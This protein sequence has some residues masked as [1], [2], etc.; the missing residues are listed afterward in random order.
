MFKNKKDIIE[1]LEAY[2]N[3]LDIPD[4]QFEETYSVQFNGYFKVFNNYLLVHTVIKDD[5]GRVW[6]IYWCDDYE[7]SREEITYRE[8]KFPYRVQKLY[9]S[10]KAEYYGVFRE[11]VESQKAINQALL[12][13]QLMANTQKIFLEKGA[14]ENM[15]DF[16]NQINRVNAI[17]PML[18]LKKMRIENMTKD[19][20]DQYTII[21]RAFS[22]I[23]KIL[24][25]NDS[26]LGMAFASDSGRK[27]KL[28]Q[29]QTT[30]SL[31][32]IT[33]KFS[34]FYR[35]L[36]WDIVNLVKQYYTATQ[37]LKIADE[38]V[39]ARWIE[40]NKP[41]TMW[42]GQFDE[43]GQPIMELVYEEV[44]DPATGKPELD[45]NGNIVMAPVPT[46][47]T[48]IAFTEVDIEID[49]VAYNDED[50][51]NQLM[52]ETI[53]QGNIG[54]MLSQV[55]PS[56]FLQAAALAVKTMKTKHSPEISDIIS[57]TAQMLAQTG[58]QPAPVS[59]RDQ[60]KSQALKLPQNTNE[61]Q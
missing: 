13:I 39:G 54:A 56:G 37:V 60:P 12:K 26:F 30:M 44:L 34:Q 40:L 22:R 16:T 20:V 58:A 24:G 47:E 25:I 43:A 33:T 51:K 29:N 53:L 2:N 45:D 5:E 55:N 36:G 1:K 50:E 15:A 48:E 31:R 17:V 9:Y 52:I 8:V 3:H 32:P 57:Q 11:V 41:M 21:D 27:V 61:G 35:L 49:S 6:S 4:S 18:S 38:T 7:L 28:Q 59:A 23:Q 10:N 46:R 19:I 14:V 42:T